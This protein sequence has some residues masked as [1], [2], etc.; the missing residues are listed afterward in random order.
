M[1]WIYPDL[2]SLSHAAAGLFVRQ[3]V[4]CVQA[5]GRF[6][7]ALAGGRTPRRTYEL[8]AQSPYRHQVDW[9]RIHVFWGDERCVPADDPRSNALMARQ[10]LLDQVPIPA[11]Q[12]HPILCQDSPREA[13]ARY[14]A[15]LRAFFGENPP[16]L[17]LI[18][19]DWEPTA[20]PPPFSPA[21]RPWRRTAGPPRFTGGR[22]T[23]TG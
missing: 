13:A 7:V 20:I 2:K 12:V 5:R 23:C 21:A 19:L 6:A 18:L 4:G 9:P 17:D 16:A 14:E 15:Q 10:A 22:K 8:L 3:A 11:S 1:L